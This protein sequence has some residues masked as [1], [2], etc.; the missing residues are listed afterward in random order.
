MTPNDPRKPAVFDIE[1]EERKDNG[2]PHRRPRHFDDPHVRVTPDEE[3]PFLGDAEAI[4]AEEGEPPV[5]TMKKRGFSFT[6]LAA[7]AFGI[8]LSLAIGLWIDD[9]VRSLFARAP[10]LGWLALGAVVVGIFAA[11]V[12]AAREA[13]AVL[14]LGAIQ[15]IKL[16]LAEAHAGSDS[17]AARKAV[18]E[19]SALVAAKAET[20]RGRQRLRELDDAVVDAPQLV[21]LAE[22]EMMAPLDIKARALILNASKRVSVVTAISPRAA[23]D[24]L[25]VFYESVRLIRNMAELYG[26]RP[27]S[28]GLTR[29]IRDVLAHLAVTGSI[30]VG[31]SL[32][33]QVLGHGLAS[34]LSARFGEGMING[35]M[36]A[37]IGIA[38]MD[39]CRPMPF[40]ALKR[41]GIGDFINDLG[42]GERRDLSNP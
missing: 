21:E 23:V 4:A 26:G 19:L 41:P 18:G 8:V 38:A 33:Q 20:A 9:L 29:L 35:L 16:G 25:Y 40:T 2:A 24:I 15:N 34:K 28:I 32:V 6:K 1:N 11:I 7:A 39:L 27:G 14:R 30:A 42:P 17:A 31:D 37:R 22:R 12:V 3:D 36:T 5:A 13:I 10:W